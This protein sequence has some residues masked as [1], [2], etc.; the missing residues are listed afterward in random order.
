MIGQEQIARLVD[1]GDP[2]AADAILQGDAGA[3]GEW[4]AQM[5]TDGLLRSLLDEGARRSMLRQS[6]LAAI[7]AASPE[8]LRERVLR[9][10]SGRMRSSR[11][12]V[13]WLALLGS[14]LA[15]AASVVMALVVWKAAP[16]RPLLAD[17]RGGVRVIRGGNGCPAGDGVS[18]G[19]G[20]RLMLDAGAGA[21]VML[22]DRSRIALSGGTIA[23]IESPDGRRMT[24]DAGSVRADI[25]PQ[26]DGHG[27]EIA[28]PEAR[29]RVL[30]TA[31]A[32]D[33]GRRRTRLEVT[34][35][36]VRIDHASFASAVE[37]AAGEFA[38]AL[39]GQELVAGVKTPD[40]TPAAALRDP[41]LVRRP[42][43]P[44]SP[45]NRRIDT[46]ARFQ[47]I[48]SEALDLA[49]HGALV[50]PTSH[51]RPIWVSA[52]DDPPRRILLRYEG[53][54]AHTLRAPDIGERQVHGTLIDP[55]AGV[56]YELVRAARRGA[57]IEAMAC[58]R[59]DLG[60][61][62]A[63]PDQA[64]HLY[65]G[66]PL[67]GGIIRKEELETGI[68]HVLA[69]AA[70]HEGLSRCGP[71]GQPFVPPARHMPIELQKLGRLGAH[72][73]VCYGT[74]LAIP[75]HVDL[76]A[77]TLSP[78]A[79]EIARA[80]QEYGAFVTHSYPAVPG[81][82]QAGWVQPHLWFFAES[83]AGTDIRRLSSE[84]SGI[85]RHLEVV[86]P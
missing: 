26:R 11:P 64:G 77:F 1:E 85:V 21:T 66:L 14:G 75:R 58:I 69:V 72:G 76:A 55:V 44:D 74:R 3:L 19:A 4:V 29:M 63:P 37:V 71:G 67:L 86:S 50:T 70:L 49:G 23:V 56:A 10:T 15:A 27:V 80:L 61:S 39:P 20:D 52:A 22:S 81:A 62:G 12:R 31:F 68:P 48:Q 38:I 46:T 13:V 2:A 83:A 53:G 32:V 82:S 6:I 34:R 9:D 16:A 7:R 8:H 5:R 18:L 60:G 45:W 43:A 42:F 78:A 35:G 59:Y 47:K 51:E 57:D 73:N 25:R 41:G 28:T 40:A 17:V 54:V 65:S 36:L 84:V 24:L 30:G 79:L 33:A